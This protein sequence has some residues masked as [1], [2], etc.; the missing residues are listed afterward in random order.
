MDKIIWIYL[1]VINFAGFFTMMIDKRKAVHHKWRIPE[2]N[3]L[4]IGFLGGSI[5]SM[6]GM[7]TF[8]HKTKHWYFK[9]LYTL[10]LI[11]HL[12]ILSYFFM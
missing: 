11:I 10:F 5:G 2:F 4:L 3:L 1:I 12:L 6:F 9:V 7:Y 8:R